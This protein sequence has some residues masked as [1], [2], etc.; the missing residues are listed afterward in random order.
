[1]AVPQAR[2]GPVIAA[3]VLALFACV[4]AM[5]GFASVWLGMQGDYGQGDSAGV[6][7]LCAGFISVAF[8]IGAIGVAIASLR[9]SAGGKTT[10]PIAALAAA[11]TGALLALALILFSV[12]ALVVNSAAVVH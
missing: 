2:T 1:M 10:M 6:T 11:C 7:G 4:C 5:G 8:A 3:M 9:R 12:L